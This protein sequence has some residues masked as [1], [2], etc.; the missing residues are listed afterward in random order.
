MPT[1]VEISVIENELSLEL[2]L[3][4][5]SE[6]TKK[7]IQDIEKGIEMSRTF[8]SIEELFNELEI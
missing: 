4:V 7:V 2:T 8:H 6:E 3:D 5:P 1:D